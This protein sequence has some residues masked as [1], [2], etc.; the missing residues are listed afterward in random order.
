MNKTSTKTFVRDSFAWLAYFMLAYYS[1]LQAS[2]GPLMP[3]LRDE[4]KLNYT[5]GAYHFSAF[6]IGMILAGVLGDRMARH[7][8]RSL[9]FWGGSA[10]MALGT[11]LLTLGNHPAL[12]IAGALTMGTI[13]S[14][15]LVTI[16]AGLADKYGENRATALTESNIA[17]SFS[18]SLAPLFVGGFAAIALGWRAALIAMLVA[19][20]IVVISCR[21]I[22]VPSIRQS[23]SRQSQFRGSLPPIFWIYWLVILFGVSV[24]WGIISWGADFLETVVGL[25]KETASISMTA[26]LGA[27]VVGRF[28]GSRLTYVIA[29]SKLLLA[30]AVSALIGFPMFWLG[31]SVPVNIIGLFIAGIG[32]ANLFPMTLSVATNLAPEQPDTTSARISFGAGIAIFLAPQ[33]LGYIAD[34]SSIQTAYGLI[35]ILLVM[36]TIVILVANYFAHHR[37]WQTA[38]AGD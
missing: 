6:A 33:F 24:E 30:A 3:F 8:G 38:P 26:F 18:A 32:V 13:G 12:T 10:G 14:L 35:G 2:L 9:T 16:Q 36:V 27:M 11:L 29:S 20:L 31:Q 15:L 23:I 19:W 1:Y 4:L 37:M 5:I 21:R 7:W 17:A 22:S 28:T 25:S 34:Q